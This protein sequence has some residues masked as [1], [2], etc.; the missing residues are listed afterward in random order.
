[1]PCWGGTIRARSV[2]IG[3]AKRVSAGR[4]RRGTII[5]R[6]GMNMYA[7]L[8]LLG[9]VVLLSTFP[10]IFYWFTRP[11]P[12]SS[13]RAM[14]ITAKLIP[15]L[16]CIVGY[17]IVFAM[18][19]VVWFI[20]GMKG[21][22]AGSYPMERLL[23]FPLQVAVVVVVFPAVAALLAIAMKGT[24]GMW[25]FAIGAGFV[26]YWAGLGWLPVEMDWRFVIAFAVLGGL[27][28][29]AAGF[30]LSCV[31]QPHG[32][33]GKVLLW[34]I[35]GASSAAIGMVSSWPAVQGATRMNGFGQPA[36]IDY[37]P[38]SINPW[39]M[40]PLLLTCV[41]TW[42]ALSTFAAII[43][44]YIKVDRRLPVQDAAPE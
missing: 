38:F 9:Q 2:Y 42:L 43:T 40:L 14:V 10:F 17:V 34:S 20:I 6:H 23:Q 39:V 35:L 33:L 36:S 7:L 44:G 15:G 11:L 19:F 3:T 21:G 22:G 30:I 25:V 26:S 12:A 24:L 32:S 13:D 27:C 41:V 16:F 31:A 1:M 8:D 18:D 37:T 28:G 4:R 29:M 5:R